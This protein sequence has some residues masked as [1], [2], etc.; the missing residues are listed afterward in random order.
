MHG[1]MGQ[2]VCPRLNEI[3]YTIVKRY[4]TYNTFGHGG[5][6]SRV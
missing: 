3:D 2:T 4:E 6:A 5:N 1:M